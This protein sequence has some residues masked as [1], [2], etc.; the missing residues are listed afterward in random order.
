MRD[1]LD[2]FGEWRLIEPSQAEDGDKPA[3]AP[4]TQPIVAT[5][6]AGAGKTATRFAALLG[7]AVLGVTGLAIWITA[8]QPHVTFDTAI[9]QGFRGLQSNAAAAPSDAVSV[10]PPAQTIIVDIEGA[11]AEPGLHPL[12]DGS[13][14]GDAIAAAG[15]YGPRVDISAVATQLN[16]ARKLTDG[17][18]VRVPALGDI[19]AA[20]PS[21]ASS[22]SGGGSGPPRAGGLI[23]VNTASADELDTLPGIG[24]VT[25]AKIIA[26]REQAPFA[27]VDELLSRQIVG[28]STFEKLRDLVTVGS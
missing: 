14:I 13:R 16:L 5:G 28:A 7:A 24:P 23:N 12:P 4:A 20:V 22:E 21:P 15:G 19:V 17:E 11:V 10:L 8:P 2:K 25:A 9:Q 18:K 3:P 26:A 6:G 27:T 1:G